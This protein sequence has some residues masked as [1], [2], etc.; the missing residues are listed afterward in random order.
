MIFLLVKI[1]VAV[2][3]RKYRGIDRLKGGWA[4]PPEMR[5]VGKDAR[6]ELVYFEHLADYRERNF[7][8]Q[9]L[10]VNMM[11]MWSFGPSFCILKF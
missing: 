1:S 11:F 7:P 2:L 10:F 6:I 9:E 3:G 5:G 8:C 4:R